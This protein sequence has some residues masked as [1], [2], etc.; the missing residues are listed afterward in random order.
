M[1]TDRATLREEYHQFALTYLHGIQQ[2]IRGG[3]PIT[4]EE[5]IWFDQKTGHLRTGR[6]ARIFYP[7]IAQ[8]V[9]KGVKELE[10]VQRIAR[11]FWTEVFSPLPHY[12]FQHA[13][14]ASGNSFEVMLSEIIASLSRPI[15]EA[16]IMHE[17]LPPPLDRIMEAFERNLALWTADHS[18][19]T[20]VAPLQL[21]E[22]SAAYDL[23]GAIQIGPF[24]ASEKNQILDQWHLSHL[25][26][27]VDV[28]GLS[29]ARSRFIWSVRTPFPGSTANPE[30][31]VQRQFETVSRKALTALRLLHPGMVG[32]DRVY[33][34]TSGPG[35]LPSSGRVWYDLTCR[36]TNTGTLYT[37]ATTDVDRLNSRLELIQKHSQ[38]NMLKLALDRFNQGYSRLNLV[39]RLIDSVVAL[40]S[41]LTDRD[42]ISYKFKMRGAALLAPDQDPYGVAKELRDLYDAR[43]SVVHNGETPKNLGRFLQ[44]GEQFCRDILNTVLER[45]DSIIIQGKDA[46]KKRL[47]QGIDKMILA[48]LAAPTAP[49]NQAPLESDD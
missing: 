29:T 34:R 11:L 24:T 49:E 18:E 28:P 41:I 8:S 1:T 30:R 44:S 35:L 47:I 39:D 31:D 6:P 9:A 23:P 20:I 25:I 48:R 16:A 10:V 19:W 2:Q 45:F 17:T 3:A 33:V 42:D 13:S 40:E 5:R 14:A 37:L 4:T 38:S 22:V 7:D 21:C 32:F 27:Q 43:S 36:A 15:Y 12:S 26:P 46:E